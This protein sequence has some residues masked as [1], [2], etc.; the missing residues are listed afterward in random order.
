MA[1]CIP[2][3]RDVLQ[4]IYVQYAPKLYFHVDMNNVKLMLV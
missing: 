3:S 2:M 4:C 1:T